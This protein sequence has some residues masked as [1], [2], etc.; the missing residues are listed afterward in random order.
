MVDVDFKFKDK[1]FSFEDV[2][3]GEFFYNVASATICLKLP[4][5]MVKIVRAMHT[6]DG[7]FLEPS[8][9]E[10]YNALE[11]KET[12]SGYKSELIFIGPTAIT[13]KCDTTI[14]ANVI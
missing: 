2:E 4:E 14:K 9:Y 13:R 6:N 12:L 1:T 5:E 11:F 8:D 3:E 7:M 10:E